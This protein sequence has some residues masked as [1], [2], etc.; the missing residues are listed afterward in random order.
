MLN[1]FFPFI[2]IWYISSRS[3][4]PDCRQDKRQPA[5]KNH[6]ISRQENRAFSTPR[7]V[8]LG[9]PSLEFVRAGGARTLTSQPKFLV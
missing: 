5:K 8:V 7:Q 1:S 2:A 4:L 9:L 6:A 3:G